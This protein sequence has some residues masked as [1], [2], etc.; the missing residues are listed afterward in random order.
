MTHTDSSSDP[1]EVQRNEPEEVRIATAERVKAEVDAHPTYSLI[2]FVGQER[3][4]YAP[5]TEARM[6]GHIYSENGKSEY[7][8]S[9]TCE[10]HFDNMFKED[11]Y[12]Q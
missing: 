4:F 5:D 12:E 11:D 2:C 10:Y 9:K 7:G 6:P 1:A 8:I 3:V